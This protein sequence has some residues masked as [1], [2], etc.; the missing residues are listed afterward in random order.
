MPSLGDHLSKAL[1]TASK[2]RAEAVRQRQSGQR[3]KPLPKTATEDE[4][5][6]ASAGP[7]SRYIKMRREMT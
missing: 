1:E 4:L 3:P 5:H 6:R 7:M 2:R